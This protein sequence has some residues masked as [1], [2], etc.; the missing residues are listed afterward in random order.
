MIETTVIVQQGH[1]NAPCP[2][3]AQRDPN[4]RERCLPQSSKS[5][6]PVQSTYLEWGTEDTRNPYGTLSVHL[7]EKASIV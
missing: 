3:T 2:L 4:L 7:S 6:L 5:K 1:V